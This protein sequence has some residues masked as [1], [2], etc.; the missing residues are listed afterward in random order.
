VCRHPADHAM[1][2]IPMPTTGQFEE[3]IRPPGAF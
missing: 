1:C 2:M 3:L